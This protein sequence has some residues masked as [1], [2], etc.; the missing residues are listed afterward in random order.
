MFLNTIKLE[1]I[2]E[3]TKALEKDGHARAVEFLKDA[4]SDGQANSEEI[5]TRAEAAGIKH[6]DLMRAKNTVGIIADPRGYGKNQKVWWSI[7]R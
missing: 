6:S 7:P 2:S 5:I 1:R 3:R 4:L